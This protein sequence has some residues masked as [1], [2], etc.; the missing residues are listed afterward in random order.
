MADIE[1]TEAGPDKFSVTVADGGQRT[2]HDVTVPPS[3]VSDRLG[4]E[5]VDPQTVV[6]ESFEFLL[7]REPASSIMD[8]F[9]LDVISRYFPEYEE[10]LERRLSS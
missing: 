1:V 6:R 5:S 8:S 9:S 10:E 4:V 7:E 3:F 2:T